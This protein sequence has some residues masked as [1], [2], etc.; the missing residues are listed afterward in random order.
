MFKKTNLTPTFKLALSAQLLLLCIL[1]YSQ[2]HSSR[3]VAA[4]NS[5]LQKTARYLVICGE[6][7]RDV[8][9]IN[10]STVMIG[11][12]GGSDISPLASGAEYRDVNGDGFR[13]LLLPLNEGESTPGSIGA[14]RLTGSTYSGIPVGGSW[15]LADRDSGTGTILALHVGSVQ[16]GPT[17]SLGPFRKS[18]G[19]MPVA[20]RLIPNGIVSSCGVA[21]ACPGTEVPVTNPQPLFNSVQDAFRTL[22]STSPA[23]VTVTTTAISCSSGVHTTA[24]IGDHINFSDMCDGYAGDSG[25]GTG[26]GGT[27]TFSFTVPPGELYSLVFVGETAGT[28]CADF[29]Y[30]ISISPCIV[31]C[32]QDDSTGDQITFSSERGTFLFRSCRFGFTLTGAGTATRKGSQV[33]LLDYEPRVRVVARYDESTKKGSASVVFIPTNFSATIIDRDITNNTCECRNP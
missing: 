26:P 4:R 23:C 15:Y 19:D 14:L 7:N 1:T 30:S 21:K 22:M 27:T 12:A 16:S 11:S 9:Q 18:F 33:T 2:G 28:Q 24:I 3:L 32:I 6:P 10:S 5:V 8:S 25:V 20:G 17:C 13:D 31:L 29:S